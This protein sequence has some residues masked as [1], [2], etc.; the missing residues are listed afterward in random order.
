MN[1]FKI[2]VIEMPSMNTFWAQINEPEYKQTI[3]RIFEI[4]NE[5]GSYE[6]RVLKQSELYEGLMV[7]A[8]FVSEDSA[9]FYRAKILR[10]ERDSV[11]V[12]IL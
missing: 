9:D 3:D 7:V 12:I 1:E 5:Q 6:F 4:L 8:L 10:I 11:E 2:T